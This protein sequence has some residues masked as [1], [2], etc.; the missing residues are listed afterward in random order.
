M[1]KWIKIEG[2]AYSGVW[3]SEVIQRAK[4]H[5]P[6][7]RNVCLI[8][9]GLG[10]SFY[11]TWVYAATNDGIEI[12]LSIA[13]SYYYHKGLWL[14]II[15]LLFEICTGSLAYGFWKW[16][17]KQK[18]SN[19]SDFGVHEFA[20]AVAITCLIAFGVAGIVGVIELSNWINMIIN[21]DYY[22][23]VSRCR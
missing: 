23:R 8:L 20:Y 1:R 16:G 17:Q 6:N 21:P 10:I 11:N 5:A 18:N 19:G 3:E 14:V 13:T 22:G 7:V 4:H 2:D 12:P 15:W 9:A